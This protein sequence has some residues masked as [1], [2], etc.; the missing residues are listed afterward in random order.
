MIEAG[1]D[2]VAA[3]SA[4]TALVDRLGWA[5]ATCRSGRELLALGLDDDV[6]MAAAHD[7]SPVVPVL[8]GE[9]FVDARARR[10]GVRE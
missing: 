9:R 2:T 6:A 3:A 1:P 5:V 8:D 10:G 7:V 4:F